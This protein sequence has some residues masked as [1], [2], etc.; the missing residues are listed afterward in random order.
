MK[1][2]LKNVVSVSVPELSQR[3]FMLLESRP[4]SIERTRQINAVIGANSSGKSRFIRTILLSEI[5]HF[6]Y[7]LGLIQRASKELNNAINN[8]SEFVPQHLIDLFKNN[9]HRLFDS[10]LNLEISTAIRDYFKSISKGASD[11]DVDNVRKKIFS[12][13]LIDL[14]NEYRSSLD[15]NIQSIRKEYIPI[16]RGL[17]TLM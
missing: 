9:S 14:M 16:L 7:N 8:S 3:N 10:N 6:D 2:E 1:L 11:F 17:R 13:N 15:F 4:H 12:K 5:N